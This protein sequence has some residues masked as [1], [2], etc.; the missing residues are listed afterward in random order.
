MST[1]KCCADFIKY[2]FM[3]IQHRG[4]SLPEYVI[5]MKT[6]SN[7]ALKSNLQLESNYADKMNRDKS[8]FKRLGENVKRQHMNHTGQFYR[9]NAGIMKASY[10]VSLLV[11]QNK[12]T[13]VITELLI[14]TAAK[15]LDR[16]LIGEESVAKLDSVSLSTFLTIL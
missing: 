1:R 4:D 8:Y 7:A 9:N 14:L 10:E 13:R 5:C 16:N 2:G 3:A 11:A 12:K 15:V 6:L